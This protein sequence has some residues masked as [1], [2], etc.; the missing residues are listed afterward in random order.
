[1]LLKRMSEH[2]ESKKVSEELKDSRSN[3]YNN[4]LILKKRSSLP[5]LMISNQDPL[6]CGT[7]MKLGLTPMVNG[8][9]LCVHTSYF[10]GKLCG[11]CKL[12]STHHSGAPYLY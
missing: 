8:T 11:R 4:Q 10:K 9:R 12:E 6:K 1:M 7:V 2:K 3:D 5:I